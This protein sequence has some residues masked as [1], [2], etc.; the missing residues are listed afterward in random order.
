MK[1][2]SN[3]QQWYPS[4]FIFNDVIF[5]HRRKIDYIIY[6]LFIYVTNRAR[7]DAWDIWYVPDVIIVCHVVNVII[8]PDFNLWASQQL[9]HVVFSQEQT[10]DRESLFVKLF[11][12]HER[13]LL[14]VFWMTYLKY[15]KNS[16]KLTLIWISMTFMEYDFKSRDHSWFVENI[17]SLKRLHFSI[18]VKYWLRNS[19][20]I[21]FKVNSNQLLAVWDEY[22][23]FLFY[24]YGNVF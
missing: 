8:I 21:F 7:W 9:A 18:Q 22:I 13:L 12:V 6:T 23:V 10:A 15:S 4:K 1:F 3:P 5:Y 17:F 11:Q 14:P 2:L 16:K 24:Q 19:Y 20:Q